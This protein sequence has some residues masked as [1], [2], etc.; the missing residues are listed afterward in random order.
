MKHEPIT[1]LLEEAVDAAPAFV[2]KKTLS[3]PVV[4]D[5]PAQAPKKRLKQALVPSRFAPAEVPATKF[6]SASGVNPALIPLK[7][8]PS[9]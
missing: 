9:P 2:P 3:L 1:T 8:E 6:S 5:L 4:T 7:F